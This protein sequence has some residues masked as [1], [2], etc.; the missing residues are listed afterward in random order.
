MLSH[1]E[2]AEPSSSDT[3]HHEWIGPTLERVAKSFSTIAPTDGGRARKA[4]AFK[5]EWPPDVLLSDKMIER[6]DHEAAAQ[7]LRDYSHGYG[8]LGTVGGYGESTNAPHAGM[9]FDK[10]LG[11]VTHRKGTDLTIRMKRRKQFDDAC[12][13][14]QSRAQGQL[15]AGLTAICGLSPIDGSPYMTFTRLGQ[16]WVP[17]VTNPA[18]LAMAGKLLVKSTCETLRKHYDAN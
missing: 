7:L 18:Q 6:E 15:I 11:A 8:N 10:R 4:T 5:I 12:R 14:L 3:A 2:R 9:I 16:W 17:P 1:H 13:F